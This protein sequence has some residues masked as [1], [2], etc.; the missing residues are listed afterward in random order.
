MLWLPAAGRPASSLKSQIAALEH[1]CRSHKAFRGWRPSLFYYLFAM[2]GAYWASWLVSSGITSLPGMAAAG[3][4]FGFLCLVPGAANHLALWLLF[5][6]P[7]RFLERR[8][9]PLRAE[10][11]RRAEVGPQTAPA[12]P[13][14]GEPQCLPAP[15]PLPDSVSRPASHPTTAGCR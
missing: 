9:A 4:G 2:V 11:E 1:Q 10:L 7:N 13:A 12:L 15:V 5:R 3:L 6:W 14:P 8:I